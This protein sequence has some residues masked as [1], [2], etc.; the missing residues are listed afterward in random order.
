MDTAIRRI[1]HL[2]R[3]LT[4]FAATCAGGCGRTVPAGQVMCS[5]CANK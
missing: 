3:L 5:K 2:A 4:A 1:A